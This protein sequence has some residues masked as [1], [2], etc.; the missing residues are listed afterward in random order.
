MTYL[1]VMTPVNRK[2]IDTIVYDTITKIHYPTFN[3]LFTTYYAYLDKFH[4]LLN[5]DR[6]N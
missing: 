6:L 5:I 2:Y 1:R 4:K 3:L